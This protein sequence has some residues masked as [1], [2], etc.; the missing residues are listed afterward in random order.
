M[1]YGEYV[2]GWLV[3]KINKYFGDHV[4]LNKLSSEDKGTFIHEY[5][6][7]LQDISTASGLS[8]INL[9]HKILHKCIYDKSITLS[10]KLHVQLDNDIDDVLVVN[11][12]YDGNNGHYRKNVCKLNIGQYSYD[13][14][15]V[16]E[17][18]LKNVTSQKAIYFYY[19]GNNE[20]YMF[21]RNC[22]LESMAYLIEKILTHS[23]KRTD[24]LPYNA[25]E[26]V[27]KKMYPDG[28][29]K[30]HILVAVCELSLMHYNSSMM[31][32]DIINDMKENRLYFDN[33]LDL[34]TRYKKDI[35]GLWC[36]IHREI[37]NFKRTIKS[38]YNSKEGATLPVYEKLM[39]L[40]SRVKTYRCHGVC[41][42]FI[43]YGV[44]CAIKGSVNEFQQ[45]L[46]DFG[47]G[48]LFK[49]ALYSG[50]SS[51][52]YIN[53]MGL[54]AVKKL[55]TESDNKCLLY[56]ICYE[57]NNPMFNDYCKNNPVRQAYCKDDRCIV[58]A[59]IAEYGLNR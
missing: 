34:W 47:T 15:D 41:P 7:F 5:I 25:C 49:N 4:D 50:E 19:D 13:A 30:D 11:E 46:K 55:F 48:A 37:V 38:I 29:I 22:I 14:D 10:N 21:G 18:R 8:R 24:E 35:S 44:E 1:E 56:D 53:I 23:P 16:I 12:Y 43:A 45:I 9:E 20:K 17:D 27:W 36:N 39:C 40:L 58:G 26:I 42:L 59:L 52:W 54:Y 2:S 28:K 31:F 3:I 57:I 32:Y 33:V 6:H 51:R